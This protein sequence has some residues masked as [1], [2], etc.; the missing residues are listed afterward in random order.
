[1]A[2]ML[3]MD[4]SFFM[5]SRSKKP[6]IMRAY[7]KSWSSRDS[8]F[9]VALDCE[10]RGYLTRSLR[11]HYY[12][13]VHQFHYS[14]RTGIRCGWESREWFTR[15][16]INE[17]SSK[18][19]MREASLLRPQWW[20]QKWSVMVVTLRLELTKS[21]H[22]RFSIYYFCLYCSS[23][24]TSLELEWVKCFLFASSIL[25]LQLV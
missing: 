6:V 4:S 7:N 18:K 16:K 22:P 24:V 14:V 15:F 11:L 19:E 1:M 5:H 20:V 12:I 8:R 2:L 10:T 3:D 23:S 25:I 13:T 9:S 17:E 21:P